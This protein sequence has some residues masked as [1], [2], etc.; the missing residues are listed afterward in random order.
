MIKRAIL[1]C[2]VLSLTIVAWDRATAGSISLDADK[3]KAVLAT[4]KPEEDGFVDRVVAM[5][6]KG[7][8]PVSL[9]DS[10]LQWARKKPTFKFQYFRRAL[11]VRA[12]QLGIEI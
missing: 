12:A 11:I 3:I 1:A 6:E 10:T 7:K 4:A 2:L 5:V 8:L 9:V